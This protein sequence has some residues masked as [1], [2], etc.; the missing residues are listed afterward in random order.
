VPTHLN[1]VS[2][3]RWQGAKGRLAGAELTLALAT[4]A[5]VSSVTAADGGFGRGHGIVFN[6][7][8]SL[9]IENRAICNLAGDAVDFLPST[10]NNLAVSNTLVA[11]IDDNGDGDPAPL[12]TPK[13]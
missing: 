6:T 13:K 11:N 5:L 7:G 9:T 2:R 4:T 3:N 8:R 12:T 1:V 10:S